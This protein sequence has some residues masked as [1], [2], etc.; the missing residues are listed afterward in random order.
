MLRPPVSGR[1]AVDELVAS[2]LGSEHRDD[3][4]LPRT[5]GPAGNARLTAWIGL[6]LLVLSVVELVTL[7]RLQQL[8]DVHLVVG[9]ALVPLMLV[10]TATTGWR[11]GRYYLGSA[12]YRTAGPPPILLRVLGPFV[13]LSGL[14]VL[15][16]G[17]AL[18][19]LGQD[20]SRQAVSVAGFPVDAVALHKVAF[21]AWLVT[22]GLHV[23]ARTVPALQLVSGR[24]GRT[25]GVPGRWPRSTVAVATLAACVVAGAVVLAASGD[26]R[27][28]GF[29]NFGDQGDDRGI[30]RVRIIN[31]S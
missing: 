16:T 26:W 20:G 29:N 17:L 8:I 24:T 14:A 4:V 1:Q 30:S 31:V 27:S 19:A 28:G 15:G 21:A 9:A 18:V 13:V 22:T 6:T 12:E 11:M 5:G 23:L 2:A 3:P 25:R 7:L 10:K